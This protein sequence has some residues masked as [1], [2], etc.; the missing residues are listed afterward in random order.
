MP[1]YLCHELANS[2]PI[3]TVLRGRG[4]GLA[5]SN[6][7]FG[8]LFQVIVY[9]QGIFV[10]FSCSTINQTALKV[11]TSVPLLEVHIFKTIVQ[12]QKNTYLLC[13]ENI[14]LIDSQSCSTR[15]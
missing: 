12:K 2:P 7:S 8:H 15:K 4:G 10:F 13:S 5:D 9:F 3:S 6:S 14:V 11:L 1:I